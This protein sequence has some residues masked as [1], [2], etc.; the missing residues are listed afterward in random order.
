VSP[1]RESLFSDSL[2]QS[3]IEQA[4]NQQSSLPSPDN[5]NKIKTSPRKLPRVSP[6]KKPESSVL[7]NAQFMVI[8]TELPSVKGSCI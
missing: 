4:Q 6:I 7:N 8:P 5:K 2:N 1:V 3:R